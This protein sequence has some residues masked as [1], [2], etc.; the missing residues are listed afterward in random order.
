MRKEWLKEIARDFI[1]FGSIPFLALTIVRVSVI[2]LYYPMQFIISS[3]IFLVLNAIFRAEMRL[4][5]GLILLVFTSIFYH[6]PLFTIFAALVYAGMIVSAF[7]LE[8]GAARI[9][10]GIFLGIISAG[11]GF[12]I[13][14]A[15]FFR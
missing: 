13:V 9:M 14:R 2:R 1:A 8:R 15:L 12:A 10:G 3:A 6:H 11:A 4:G 5:I 7:Y